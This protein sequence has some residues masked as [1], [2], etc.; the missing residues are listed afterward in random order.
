MTRDLVVEF[1]PSGVASVP[2]VPL[3]RLDPPITND[4]LSRAVKWHSR[5][6]GRDICPFCWGRGE[7]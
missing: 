5:P 2:K 3:L 1:Y 4:E 7:R 6:G